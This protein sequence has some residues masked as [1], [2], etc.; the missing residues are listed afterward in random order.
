M[1]HRSSLLSARAVVIAI[2]GAACGGA[3]SE[4]AP[5]TPSSAPPL[6][7]APPRTIEEAQEQIARARADL[8]VSGAAAAKTGTS[9]MSREP[10][11]PG[12]RPDAQSD[13]GENA[14]RSPCQALDSMRRAVD[15]LCRMTGEEDSRCGD[16][17]RTLTDSTSRL[18]HCNCSVR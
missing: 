10:K 18:S 2:G 5:R 16:A 14:C 8:D 15:A 4:S 17:K 3:D 11:A 6:Y 7:A 13:R 12:E 1:T 9:D